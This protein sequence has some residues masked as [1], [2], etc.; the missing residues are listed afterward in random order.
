MRVKYFLVALMI[1]YFF[2]FLGSVNTKAQA[3]DE[4]ANVVEAIAPVYPPFAVAAS[5]EGT[6]IAGI[7][8]S[9]DGRVAATRI[10]GESEILKRV[11][12]IVVRRWRFNT[13]TG[14]HRL[15]T[16]QVTFIFAIMPAKS[17]PEDL[18]PIF[19]PPYQIEIRAKRPRVD[20]PNA[21]EVKVGSQ[22]R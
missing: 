11:V 17:P 1:I 7:T 14:S 20:F 18:L 2:T 4:V 6:I 9:S 16:V 3:R 19:R 15:R 21:N 13:I 8:I 12:D 22:I 5:Q 10:S